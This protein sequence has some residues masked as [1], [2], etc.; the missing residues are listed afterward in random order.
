MQFGTCRGTQVHGDAWLARIFDNEDDFSRLDF[1]LQEVSSGAEWVRTAKAQRLAKAQDAPAHE[2]LRKQ[3]DAAG[4]QQGGAQASAAQGPAGA[5]ALEPPPP[6]EAARVRLRREHAS[7]RSRHV[8]ARRCASA[9]S[10]S[11][12]H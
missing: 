12:T 3:I 11:S 7:P 8:L 1:T 4:A 2:A 9:G 5:R 10:T 6:A